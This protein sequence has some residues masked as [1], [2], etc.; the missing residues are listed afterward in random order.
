MAL[1]VSAGAAPDRHRAGER[2]GSRSARPPSAAPA[3]ASFHGN[4]SRPRASSL[5]DGG[6]MPLGFAS[7]WLVMAPLAPPTVAW[8]S[9]LVRPAARRNTGPRHESS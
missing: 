4:L 8:Q 6:S 7:L 3:W 5:G 2:S 9:L 1:V